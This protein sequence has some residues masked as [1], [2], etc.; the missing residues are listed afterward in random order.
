MPKPVLP[1]KPN[2]RTYA[3]LTLLPHPE[4]SPQP[5]P[6]IGINQVPNYLPL[7]LQPLLGLAS[8]GGARQTSVTPIG[9]GIGSG[10]E[11]EFALLPW[12]ALVWPLPSSWTQGQVQLGHSPLQLLPLSAPSSLHEV[13]LERARDLTSSAHN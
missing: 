3:P 10:V 8:L 1:L 11:C 2:F 4:G 12:N 9:V 6:S 7:R 13:I 5:R